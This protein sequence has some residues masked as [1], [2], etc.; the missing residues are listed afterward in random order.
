MWLAWLKQRSYVGRNKKNIAIWEPF[1]EVNLATGMT[2]Q[3][4]VEFVEKAVTY[5]RKIDESGG[6]NY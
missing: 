4:G 5:L 6:N 3:S 2:E 1:A